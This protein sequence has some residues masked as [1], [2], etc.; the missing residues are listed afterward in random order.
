MYG[1]VNKAVKDLVIEN[2]GKEKWELISKDAK[3]A[4]DEFIPL[5][6]YDDAITYSLVSSA[7]KV[8]GIPPEG[9][10]KAFG[11]YWIKFTAHEGYGDLMDLFGQN[12]KDCLMNLNQMHSRMGA[13]MPSLVPPRFVVKESQDGKTI[14]L[15]YY[16]ARLGLAPMVH[17]LL[18]G[19]AEKHNTK[20][21]IE[22][23]ASKSDPS[24]PD[25]FHIEYVA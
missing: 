24:A 1:L 25:V 15:E 6:T 4:T 2:F 9:V 16:S 19:L 20:V 12:F 3:L 14:S 10:L 22:Q 17:G 21:K 8:L 18:E 13:M 7:T 11:K 5:N 23:T